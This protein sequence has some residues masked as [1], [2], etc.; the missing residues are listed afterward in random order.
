M[1]EKV[2]KTIENFTFCKNLNELQVI[3][4]FHR[5]KLTC[6]FISKAATDLLQDSDYGGSTAE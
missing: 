3:E 2:R 1:T 6:K 5:C 4:R